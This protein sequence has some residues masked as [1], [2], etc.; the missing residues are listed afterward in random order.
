MLK[1]VD[2]PT[3]WILSLVAVK[4]PGKLRICI[5]LKDLNEALKQ[6]HYPFPTIEEIIPGLAKAKVFLVLDDKDGFHQVELDEE[7]SYL[8]TF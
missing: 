7:S 5:C 8:T 2:T 6:N 3:D 1:K 4:K